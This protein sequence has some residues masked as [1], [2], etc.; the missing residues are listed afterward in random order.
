VLVRPETSVE[1]IADALGKLQVAVREQLR[2]NDGTPVTVSIGAAGLSADDD[3][4][5]WLQRADKELYAAKS[6][7]RDCIKIRRA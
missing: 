4:G 2:A 7:G 3:P 5:Q 1:C 6:A